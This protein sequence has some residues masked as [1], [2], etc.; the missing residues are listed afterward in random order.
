MRLGILVAAASFAVTVGLNPK[1]F[2]GMSE[3]GVLQTAETGPEEFRAL[4]RQLRAF[5]P[6]ECHGRCKAPE[7]EASFQ[8]IREE[9]DAFVA[10]H[11]DFDALDL[12][13]ACYLAE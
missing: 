6:D 11:P 5:H 13:K 4:R 7:F 8:A 10:A 1:T 3:E 9:L 12:R 2:A